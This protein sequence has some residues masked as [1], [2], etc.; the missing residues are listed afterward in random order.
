MWR[1]LASLVLVVGLAGCGGGGGSPPTLVGVS[2]GSFN[3]PDLWGYALWVEEGGYATM[4]VSGDLEGQ[5]LV[6][7]CVGTLGLVLYGEYGGFYGGDLAYENEVLVGEVSG[8]FVVECWYCEDSVEWAVWEAV[9][10]WNDR[11]GY[12]AVSLR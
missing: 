11:A 8:K 12:E 6:D 2:S 5:D 7:A 10:V 9:Q 1:I 4:G 3:N